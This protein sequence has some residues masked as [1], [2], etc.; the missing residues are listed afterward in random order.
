MG[1]HSARAC[2]SR[3]NKNRAKD[4]SFYWVDASIAPIFGKD[5]KIA[6]YIAVRFPITENKKFE[7]E[8]SVKIEELENI[9]KLMVGRELKM[10]ELKEKLAQT[11][12]EIKELRK[13][14]HH[15]HPNKKSF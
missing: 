7:E 11:E 3:R 6:K 13:K 9:N 10:V 15:E 8:L 1:Y 5:G 2:F 4:G 12:A 14:A